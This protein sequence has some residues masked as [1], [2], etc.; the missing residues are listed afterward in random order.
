MK[1]LQ[2]DHVVDKIAA[3]VVGIR[4]DVLLAQNISDLVN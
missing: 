1:T 3:L 4:D 2:H